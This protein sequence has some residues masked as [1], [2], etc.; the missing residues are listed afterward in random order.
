M[1]RRQSNILI[2][3]DM[4]K[5]IQIVAGIL[6]PAGY[7]MAF[8]RDGSAALN[9]VSS[10]Y[11]DLIL[12]DIMMPGM[13]G[14]EVCQQLKA[15]SSTQ[16]IPVIFLTAKTDPESIVKAFESGAVD[17]VTKPFNSAELKARVKTHLSLHHTKT[18][19]KIANHTKDKFFSIIAHDLKNPFNT[20]LGFS[21]ILIK[22]Y[23]RL[24]ETKKKSHIESIHD[25]AQQTY[26]LLEN[27]LEWSRMQTGRLE[28]KPLVVDLNAC[29][30]EI[31][32]FMHKSAERKKIQLHLKLPLHTT[33]YADPDMVTTVIRN[34]ISNAIKFTAQGGEVT[35]QGQTH[36][37]FEEITISDSGVGMDAKTQAKLFKIDAHHSTQGTANESGT[38]LGLILCREFIENNKGRIWVESKKGQGSNFKFTLPKNKDENQTQKK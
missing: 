23:E 10:N 28:V 24:E 4:P 13:D 14:F 5:N 17:Y 32:S 33:V 7:N 9:Q 36:G 27:L 19:L 37:D 8:A 15:C 26:K 2:V 30:F 16:N 25:A 20:I 31:I 35:I 1:T 29:A 21:G 38:G 22:Q 34:L 11:F 3:D 18:D 12:L 6:S